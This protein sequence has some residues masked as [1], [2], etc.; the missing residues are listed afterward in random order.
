LIC[1]TTSL[2]HAADRV[3]LRDQTLIR[4]EVASCDADGLLLSEARPGGAKH[5]GWDEVE[6]L[7]LDDEKL[8]AKAQKLVTDLGTPLFQIRTRLETG[9]D[10]NLLK[11][12][13]A[14][15]PTFRERRSV[16]SLMVLQALVWGRLAN[17]QRE[18]AVEPWLLEFEVLRSRSAKLTELPGTRRPLLDAPS[19]LLAELEPVWFD[20]A[21]AKSVLSAAEKALQTM[22][23]P[24][25][26]G[27]RL[28]VASLALAA[29]DLVKADKLMKEDVDSSNLASPLRQILLGQRDVQ[30]SK[31]TAAMDRLQGVV[32]ELEKDEPANDTRRKFLHPLALYWLGRAQLGSDSA[33]TKQAGLL[34]L[35]RIPALEGRLSPDLSAAALHEA[36]QF[37]AKDAAL[38]ARLRS[39]ILRQFPSS[40][41]ARQLRRRP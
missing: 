10:E 1:A 35:M 37:Y 28:Y 29:G 24:I 21:A 18:A 15:F 19:A 31:P 6:S 7:T 27:A 34:T 32:R 36:A 30:D 39:E 16:A 14:I 3:A 40:W 5:V 4:S 11:P 22:A 25:P 41:H 12:A 2:A 23:D 26:P 20:P 9:D 33:E 17:G 13:E 38:S 8:N